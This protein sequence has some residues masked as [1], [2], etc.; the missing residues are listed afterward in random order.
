MGFGTTVRVDGGSRIL[1]CIFTYFTLFLYLLNRSAS[2]HLALHHITRPFPR[3]SIIAYPRTQKQG[4]FRPTERLCMGELA[5]TFDGLPLEVSKRLRF[6]YI[7]T[8]SSPYIIY[9][10]WNITSTRS[11]S[12]CLDH[13]EV[14]VCVFCFRVIRKSKGMNE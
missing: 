4:G 2:Y 13:F 7:S 5:A 8:S 10:V 6:G 12:T 3:K 14:C 11:S 1:V 9:S